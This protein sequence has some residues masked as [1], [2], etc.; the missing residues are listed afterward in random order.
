MQRAVLNSPITKME[1]IKAINA[2][3][4]GKS[5][6][7]DGFCCEFYK[8]F[9]VI[10]VEP[11]LNMFNHSFI[12]GQFPQ[13]LKEASITLILKTGKCPES[14]ASY[15]PI[16]LLNVDR[17]LLS[18]ILASRL[19]NILPILIKEDQTGFTKGGNS[20]ATVRCLLNAVQA[21][22][23]NSS[24]GLVLSLDAEKAFNCIEWSF[25]F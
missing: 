11:L 25:L 22:K 3:Q 18:K 1:V 7:P 24:S 12:N 2:L 9:Q 8:Q 19:E 4:N 21:I 15:R 16:A 14:C 6:G 17:K 20:S 13:T 23:Q 5:P 10:L